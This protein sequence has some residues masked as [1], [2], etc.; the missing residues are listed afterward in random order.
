M[1]SHPDL[2]L[3]CFASDHGVQAPKRYE[4]QA[5]KMLRTDLVV[6]GDVDVEVTSAL[7]GLDLG[8]AL[9]TSLVQF[10]IICDGGLRTQ[11]LSSIHRHPRAFFQGSICRFHVCFGL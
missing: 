7:A 4:F 2:S 6:S 3:V 5:P 11:L 1:G 8:T 9:R 10:R